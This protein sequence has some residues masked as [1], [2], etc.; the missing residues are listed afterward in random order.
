M[1]IFKN[2]NIKGKIKE[3]I[4]NFFKS[5]KGILQFLSQKNRIRDWGHKISLWNSEYNWQIE[6]C[7]IK[8]SIKKNTLEELN[9]DNFT[10]FEM[11]LEIQKELVDKW[12]SKGKT[13]DILEALSF[14]NHLKNF[15]NDLERF[16][17]KEMSIFSIP[18]NSLEK[19][20]FHKA[21]IELIYSLKENSSIEFSL[22]SDSETLDWGS[23]TCYDNGK[24]VKERIEEHSNI[25]E[26]SEIT[27]KK[28]NTENGNNMIVS[29][30]NNGKHL[31]LIEES[32]VNIQFSKDRIH[33]YWLGVL[34]IVI[35]PPKGV[36]T[37]L[38]WV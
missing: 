30:P 35:K 6:P 24:T 9:I 13:Y 20:A 21:V 16:I 15:S 22:I 3:E 17:L 25:K 32:P 28:E 36:K 5:R 11:I 23:S 38:E 31:L 2:T 33:L 18:V 34:E 1:E 8:E 29:I 19:T 12:L 14:S 7:E 10:I 27:F 4:E 26:W 37:S